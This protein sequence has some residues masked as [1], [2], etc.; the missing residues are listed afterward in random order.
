M[1]EARILVVEDEVIIAMEIENSL[2]NLG[3]VVTAIVNSGDK[4]IIKAKEEEPDLILMD[5]HI[6]GEK[7]G[8][9][10]AIEIKSITDIP[11]VFISG[12]TD[13]EKLERA[14]LSMPYGY[15]L[16][17][18][19]ERDLKVAITMA[20]YS[21]KIERER[22]KA[23]EDFRI[24]HQ[25]LENKV[26]ERTLQLRKAKE[27]SERANQSKTDFLNKITHEIRNPLHHMLSFS[28]FGMK[29][30][31]DI[32]T[33]KIID[34][35]STIYSSGN[36]LLELIN[37]LLDISKLESGKI[38][39]NL[40]HEDVSQIIR[41]IVVESSTA[42]EEHQIEPVF[43][44]PSIS[45][46]IYCDRF[47][48]KQVLR[49]L[50]SNAVKFTPP[51]GRIEIKV[52]SD[53]LTAGRRSGDMKTVEA[54]KVSIND[55]GVGIPEGELEMIFDK[56]TQSSKTAEG[57]GGTGLGLSICQEIIQAHGGKIWAE[58]NATSG[59]VF[60]LVIPRSQISL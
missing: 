60:N 18:I 22:N 50:L 20:L 26:E 33:E 31:G 56:F 16:K 32:S 7:D 11:I 53:E 57:Y 58:N 4:A 5:I 49:N 3:Y 12:H 48:I 35:F 19:Q 55:E 1:N 14:K 8:I 39:Y 47:K 2:K 27:E 38:D 13:E 42:F 30:A 28:K 9:D 29:K 10:T 43:A 51:G 41:E 46:E 59:A 45:G 23:L 52:I 25:Q 54:L 24:L 34:Y 36:D 21:S 40:N 17:P 37:D 15:L 44:Q 6:Q